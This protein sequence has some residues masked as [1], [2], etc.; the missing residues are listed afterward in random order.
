[1]DYSTKETL[2]KAALVGGLVIGLLSIA[3]SNVLL[4]H[5]MQP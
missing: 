1:M 5:A 2:K 4:W 3:L